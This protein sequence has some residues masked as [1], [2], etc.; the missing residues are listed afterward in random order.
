[1]V[2]P[3][4]SLMRFTSKSR[5]KLPMPWSATWA[6]RTTKVKSIGILRSRFVSSSKARVSAKQATKKNDPMTSH[7]LVLSLVCSKQPP[8]PREQRTWRA[9]GSK[10][11]LYQYPRKIVGPCVLV[12]ICKLSPNFYITSFLHCNKWLIVHG[13]SWTSVVHVKAS[14]YDFGGTVHVCS[15]RFPSRV[16]RASTR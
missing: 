9:Y 14:A 1:M 10:A 3:H 13:E 7:V 6:V 2:N 5:F 12:Y 8:P 4:W 16:C 15:S 11:A